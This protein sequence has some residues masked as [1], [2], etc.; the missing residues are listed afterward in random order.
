MTAGVAAS[1]SNGW[2]DGLTGWY[3]QLHTADPG[4]SGT[5]SPTSGTVAGTRRQATMNS[6]VGGSKTLSS[7][8][9]WAG[10][11][12][13]SVTISHISVWSTAGT[14]SPATGGVFQ[15]S[16]AMTAAKA[17]NNGDTFSLTSLMMSITGLAA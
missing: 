12:G 3:V 16:A 1:I 6:A 17:I 7:G 10:W 11:D 15:F 9:S 13:G 5:G 14:G 2:L 8:P 4:A